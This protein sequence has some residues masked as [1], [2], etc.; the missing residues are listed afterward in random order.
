MAFNISGGSG[1][2]FTGGTLTSKLGL[3][4]ASAGSASLNLPTASAA[5]T[6][7]NQGDIWFDGT[8]INFR[9]STQN[10]VVAWNT[11]DP[12]AANVS[13]LLNFN[14][15]NGSTSFIDSS[16]YGHTFTAVGNAQLSTSGQK[17]G[18]ACL[19][20]DG[21]GDKIWTANTADLNVGTGAF[22][23]EFW[24]AC[25]SLAT[26]QNVF[27][28]GAY[29]AGNIFIQIATDGTLKVYNGGG[30]VFAATAAGAVTVNASYDFYQ[31]I[32][33]GSGAS[34]AA[35]KIAKNGV[36]ITASG[37]TGSYNYSTANDLY[38]GETSGG[39]TEYYNGK[40]DS[41]RFTKGV[42]RAINLPTTEFSL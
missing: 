2:S 13:L 12:Y 19:A 1:G 20:L 15:T 23:L 10:K 29:N 41:L 17:F 30:G 27:A 11:S 14:G 39:T 21:S 26:A 22:T 42:A 6:S 28:I 40:I 37:G 24:L 5:P 32:G 25:A 34:P 8:D 35:M 36:D 9:N 3:V 7:P 31:I 16:N 18:T 33:Y 38:I 4:A